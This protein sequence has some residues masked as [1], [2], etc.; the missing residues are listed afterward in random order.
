MVIDTKKFKGSFEP[1][2]YEDLRSRMGQKKYKI[3]YETEKLD[4]IIEKEYTPDFIIS[5]LYGRKMYIEAKGYFRQ[6][7]RDKL[8]AVKR[9]HPDLD[10]RI[11]FEKDNKINAR[12]RM[13]YS[14]WCNKHGFLFAVGK[15]PEEWLS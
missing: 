3:E 1:R 4:Y 11:V 6:E 12:S 7:D 8:M 9:N 15:I 10:I 14:D 2:V 13:R 5:F